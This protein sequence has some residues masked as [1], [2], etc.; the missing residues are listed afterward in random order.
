MRLN[1]NPVC[2][3][4]SILELCRGI[5]LKENWFLR[6]NLKEQELKLNITFFIQFFDFIQ[7]FFCSLTVC[8][9]FVYLFDMNLFVTWNNFYKTNDLKTISFVKNCHKKTENVVK[10]FFE[11]GSYRIEKDKYVNINSPKT[12]WYLYIFYYKT[13]FSS[14]LDTIKI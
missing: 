11:K 14:K 12:S 10:F 13:V 2:F 6:K 1:S 7:C 8:V 5:I 3:Q 4:N 9:C